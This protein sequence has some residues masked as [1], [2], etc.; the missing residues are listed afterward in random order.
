M[1][2]TSGLAEYLPH[3]YSSLKAF[4]ALADTGP[5]SLDDHRFTRFD[6]A[7]LIALGVAAPA[8]GP[9]AALRACTRTPTTCSWASS[10]R[11]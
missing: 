2:H 7:E 11:R 5:Q 8:V 6:P 10:W 4:P 3:A 1:N 9:R